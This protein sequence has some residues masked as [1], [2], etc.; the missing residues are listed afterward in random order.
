MS[1]YKKLRV[2]IAGYGVVGKRR[3]QFIDEHPALDCVAVCDQKLDAAGEFPDG[4]RYYRH[5]SE[6]LKEEL[7]ALFVCIP[8]DIAPAATIAG[9]ERGLHVFCEKPPGRNVED[10]QQVIKT[11]NANPRLK[12]KYGFNHRYHDSVRDALEIVRG[13]ELGNIISLRGLYGKS[14]IISFE[15]D[16]RTK[17]DIAGGGILLDQ[18]IH[19]V[20]LMRLFAGEFEQ[21]HSFVTNDF[22]KHDVEDNAYAL[23]RMECGVIAMLHS[24]ATQWR[25]RFQLEITLEKGMLIL[26]GILSGSKSYGAETLTVAW[27]A[28]DDRGDPREQT[29]KYNEDNSWRDEIAEFVEAIVQDR[30]IMNG[31]SLDALRTMQS[32]YRIYHADKNWRDQFGISDPELDR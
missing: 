20:D 26:S 19:M 32:V 7:E 27:A 14:A 6:L 24:S 10:I 16:W 4:V 22:W 23:I 30:P 2:G 29:T 17:R 28:D 15:S 21:V 9:L 8:N 12:L 31:T 1:V 25:H 5:Y 11:E 3:R 13:G 18:G